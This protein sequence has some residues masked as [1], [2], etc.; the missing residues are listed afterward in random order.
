MREVGGGREGPEKAEQEGGKNKK[1]SPHPGCHGPA[2][3]GPLGDPR[4]HHQSSGDPGSTTQ[5]GNDPFCHGVGSSESCGAAGG[6]LPNTGKLLREPRRSRV[7]SIRR[8]EP[9]PHRHPHGLVRLRD[10]RG[11]SARGRLRGVWGIGQ[12]A[13]ITH[14]SRR[15]RRH[16]VHREVTLRGSARVGRAPIPPRG[17]P[18]P[19]WP[20]LE[21]RRAS[22]GRRFLR[23]E[24]PG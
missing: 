5:P 4:E 9:L 10:S 13:P 22:E 14:Q 7:H 1:T 3:L 11:A 17:R 8:S 12:P 23:P 24:H 19:A 18:E 21:Q 20:G 2:G 6:A 15:A 16:R